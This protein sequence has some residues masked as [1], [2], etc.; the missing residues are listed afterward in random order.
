MSSSDHKAR[1]DYRSHRRR[2]RGRDRDRRDRDRDRA[3]DRDRSSDSG[4]KRRRE[5]AERDSAAVAKPTVEEVT[6]ETMAKQRELVEQ[7]MR[8][9]RERVARW[10]AMRKLKSRQ[11][12]TAASAGEGAADS[13]GAVVAGAAAPA[14]SDDGDEAGGGAADGQDGWSS[15]E[16]VKLAREAK[17]RRQTMQPVDMMSV[18][19]AVGLAKVAA[20]DTMEVEGDGSSADGGAPAQAGS[21]EDVEDEI[22]PLDAFMAG[23]TKEVAAIKK[24]DQERMAKL[25]TAEAAK[26]AK[27]KLGEL[28]I[29]NDD[30]IYSDESDDESREAYAQKARLRAENDGDIPGYWSGYMPKQR[31]ELGVPDHSTIDYPP[32]RR[33]FYV[34][35]PEI[36]KLQDHDVADIRHDANIKVRGKNCPKPIR[37][38]A[39]CGVHPHVLHVCKRYDYNEPTA[40]QKQ[41]IPVIMSGRD[42]MG[43]AK[44]GSGKT[45]AFIIPVFRHVLD[46][47]NGN[48]GDGPVA[49]LMTPT[50]ELALQTFTEARRFAKPLKLVAACVYGG[51]NISEQISE[52][53]RG[54]DI[55]VCTPGRMIDMLTANSGRVTNV[56][57]TTMVVLDEADRMFDLG[58]EPQ[59]MRI[60]DNIRPD[61]QTVMFSATFPRAMEALARRILKKPIEVTVGGKSV[62]S[63]TID[64]NAVVIDDHLKFSK[65]L[66]LLGHH[67]HTGQVLVFVNYQSLADRLLKDCLSA[68]YP[69]LSLHGGLDQSDRDSNIRDF[70]QGNIPLLIAT[71]VAARGLDVK[72]LTL[73]VNYDC[74]NHYEDY[75]H[76]VGR[77]GRAGNSGTAYTFITQAESKY[78]G[79]VA[80]A[81]EAQG[82]K[83]APPEVDELWKEYK[84]E[85]K[86]AGKVLMLKGSGFGGS[87]FKFDAGEAEKNAKK[88]ARQAKGL[89][90]TTVEENDGIDDEDDIFNKDKE[91]NQEIENEVSKL[92]GDNKMFDK[93]G[94]SKL[95]TLPGTDGESAAGPAAGSDSSKAS[96]AT[97]AAEARANVATDTISAIMSGS[98]MGPRSAAAEAA[99]RVF[100]LNQKL[101]IRS[102]LKKPPPPTPVTQDTAEVEGVFETTIEIN[103]FPSEARFKVT[104]K[105][106]V[107]D[108]TERSGTAITTRGTFFPP[109]AKVK[110]TDK[111]LYLFIE[112][113]TQESIDKAKMEITRILTEEIHN[114]KTKF[115]KPGS[116]GRYDVLALTGSGSGPGGRNLA[117]GHGGR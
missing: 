45:L 115:Q 84:A 39:Q 77:T 109:G 105:E 70:K 2:D 65:L 11:E 27:S 57:R 52:L 12:A 43:V 42:M 14:P 85:R 62:V 31:K 114:L 74:P 6:E 44:T 68:G 95:S 36:A 22:D 80:K 104:R 15:D 10:Q 5:G 101:G 23:V 81:F 113:K 94:V 98:A 79:D 17:R 30:A 83:K 82:L 38:W 3:R 47:V 63:D 41:A 19:D 91:I 29:G 103:D 32:F 88:K 24:F 21:A 89:G 60:L 16:D 106:F 1:W 93:D 25:E 51:T 18:P 64:Q 92:L 33:E 40:I 28:L 7:E 54:C 78:A 26:R 71:S 86:K 56:R 100:A 35:V 67:Q 46:A 8:A 66:E 72:S 9:R 37:T 49:V 53:R 34:E 111:K 75:V 69:C 117:I 87:G 13:D 90:M 107:D 102:G 99:A 20:S 110:D 61:R 50:R 116:R 59:V 73:V 76:R 48:P 112:G 55:I 58:F 96:R 4:R 108:I 97:T